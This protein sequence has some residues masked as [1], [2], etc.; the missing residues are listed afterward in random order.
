MPSNGVPFPLVFL[1]P[2][3]SPRSITLFRH[4]PAPRPGPTPSNA[5]DLPVPPSTCPAANALPRDYL[6]MAGLDKSWMK[7]KDRLDPR[8]E[9]GVNELLDFAF[10]EDR[11]NFRHGDNGQ[12]IQC[13]CK[14]CRIS[15][16]LSRYEVKT[17]L[18]CDGI[19]L[20]YTNW[21]CHGEEPI[22]RAIERSR[23]R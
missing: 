14:N 7:L 20:H 22:E 1:S 3:P 11:R 18:I 8:Y 23:D 2:R 16:K 19:W 10:H 13:P 12:L 6:E 9:K 5:A 17:H 15:G 21:V 4:P